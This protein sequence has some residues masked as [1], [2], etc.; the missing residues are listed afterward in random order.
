MEV[1][2]WLHAP[3]SLPLGKE[4][5]VPTAQELYQDYTYLQFYDTL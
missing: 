4:L 3:A 2:A 1:S 5:S